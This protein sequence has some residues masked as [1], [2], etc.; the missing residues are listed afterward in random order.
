MLGTCAPFLAPPRLHGQIK[1]GKTGDVRQEALNRR[2]DTKGR[3]GPGDKRQKIRDRRQQQTR[4][5][6]QETRDKRKE[7]GARDVRQA[8]HMSQDM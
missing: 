2:H 7:K 4:Y 6:R 8:G 1:K 5:N 3:K